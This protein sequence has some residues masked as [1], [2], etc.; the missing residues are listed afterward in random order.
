[1]LQSKKNKSKPLWIALKLLIAAAA[2]GFIYV[3]VIE[4]ENANDWWTGAGKSLRDADHIGWFLLVLI[5][6]FLNWSI[7]ALKWKMIMKKLET[8][9]FWRS[10]EAI[11]SGITI[12]FFTPNRIGEYAGRVFHLEKAD[13]IEATLLT[14]LENFSQLIV[15][16]VF[17]ALASVVYM[18]LYSAI[19]PHF[20]NAIIVL[21]MAIAVVALLIF[22]NASL[23]ETV[24]RK[25]KLPD[26]WKNYLKV[27]SIYSNSDLLKV[28]MLAMLRYII[29]SGQFYILLWIFGVEL[30]YTA[31]MILIA[32][33][34][35]VM[36]VVPTFALTELGVRGAVATFFFSAVTGNL[37]GVINASFSLW[38]VNLAAPA[39]LGIFFVFEFK[40]AR[41][42]G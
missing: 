31:A 22:F 38:L 40:F 15:T 21:L 7:E 36:S 26:N 6:M 3:R 5:L 1:M 17:G 18:E 11:F 14:V 13:R 30:S 16:L 39:L 32:V 29:F 42:K 34:Y 24:F 35:L 8:I 25:L 33:T 41:R 9:S 12:S 28:L 2:L 27:F 37:P 20:E 19:P 23:L 4:K 10:L